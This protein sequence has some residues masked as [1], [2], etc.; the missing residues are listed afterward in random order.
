MNIYDTKVI[1]CYRCDKDLGEVDWEAVV[2]A[3][4]CGDCA[5]PYPKNDDLLPC[6]VRKVAKTKNIEQPIA[7]NM[8][9]C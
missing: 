7:E 5:N 8:I 4:K 6:A 2:I 1:R 9:T 3:P